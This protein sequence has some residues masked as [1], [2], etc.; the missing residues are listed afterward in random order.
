MIDLTKNEQALQKNIERAKERNIIIPTIAQMRDPNKIPEKI[1]ESLKSVGLWDI[2]PLN[3]FRI[4]WHNEPKEQGGQFGKPNFLVLPKE[5]TGV[6]AKII[7]LIGKWFPT[8]CHKVGASFG[9]LVPRL[10]TGQFDVT[11]HKAVWPSTGNY[12]RGGAFNSKLLSCYSIAILPAEMSRERFEWLSTVA[13]ETIATPGCESNVKEIFDKTWELRT[14]R[15]DCMIF[16]QFEEMGNHLWHYNVTGPAIEEAYNLIK[17]ENSRFAGACFTSGS[18]GTTGAGDYLKDVFPNSKVGVGEALQCPTLLN[19]GFGGHRIEGIGDKHVPWIH[20][21]RNTDV[22]IDIDDEDS[23]QTL[24][25]F[26]EKA[27]REYL[28]KEAGVA[29]ELVEQLELLGISGIANVLCCIK[30]AKYY[31]L[32]ENDVL[33]T[34]LTDSSVMYGS[35][36][37]ELQDAD[38]EYSDKVAA[39]RFNKHILDQKIDNMKELTYYD[40]K[41]IHNLKYYTWVEQ[42]GRTSEELNAL[43]YDPEHTWKAVEHQADEIDAL[44][45]DFNE[46][47]GLLR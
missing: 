26:N 47:T 9:C 10:V 38:G 45:D 3:L 20:N 19:N 18:A 35:R 22:V 36:I 16:N 23:Q 13:S 32:T 8:G 30:M 27:G 11:Y 1:R 12:C 29:P 25:L 28:A 15:D 24:R 4:T 41:T 39:V 7:C 40:R 14:T 5:L 34:V 17:N 33:A 21:V 42:Q 37:K 46:R 6:D 2:N 44:I 31:E 43:W